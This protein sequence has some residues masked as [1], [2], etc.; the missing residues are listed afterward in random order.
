[1]KKKRILLKISGEIF[2]NSDGSSFD[3]DKFDAVAKTVAEFIKDKGVEVAIVSGAGNLWR[4]RDTKGSALDRV[5]ADQLG[6]TATVFNGKLLENA[7]INQ[8]VNAVVMSDFPVPELAPTYDPIEAVELMAHGITLI[9]AGGTG[10]PFFTTDSAAALRALELNCDLLIKATKVDGVYSDDPVTTPNA[11]RYSEL[12]YDEVLE[13]N[14]Q[15]M[16]L[17]AISLCR[18]NDLKV[19][20]F[21]FTDYKN[22]AKVFEDFSLGT[23][24]S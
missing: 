10:N 1:M 19:L 20:V 9:L 5:T 3:F 14:L 17:A 8:D 4:Y 15:V 22:L 24:I 6:M 21:D 23:I 18:D 7:L 11:T 13:K 12:S 16:D 2:S